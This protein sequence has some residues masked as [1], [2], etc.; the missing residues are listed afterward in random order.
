MTY[1]FPEVLKSKRLVI[2]KITNSDLD[3]F[4]KLN[5]HPDVM[6]YFSKPLSQED[7]KN[8]LE[9]FIQHEAQ[10]GFGLRVLR[11]QV[12]H[13]FLGYIAFTYVDYFKTS[14]TPCVEIGWRLNFKFWNQGFASE[15]AHFCLRSLGKDFPFAQVVSFAAIKNQA[16]LRVMQ[17]IGMSFKEAF[18]HP[19]IPEGHELRP[20]HLYQV[21]LPIRSL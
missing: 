20:H 13:Q 12:T 16:S 3:E 8:F 5:S 9:K 11:E 4:L 7:S 17:K 15:G 1:Q 21:S 18:D 6:K 19:G 10:H 2:N 14:F